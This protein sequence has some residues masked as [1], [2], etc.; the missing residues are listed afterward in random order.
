VYYL[1]TQYNGKHGGQWL[2]EE[3]IT[4]QLGIVFQSMQIPKDIAE[5][6]TVTL[7]EVHQNKIEFHNKHF[8]RLT[9]EHK[10][11]TKILD[12]LYLDKLKMR[13]TESDYDKF[14]ITLRDQLAD[15]NT[16]L[17]KLQEAEDNY[18]IT[19]KHILDLASRAYDLF[20][21]SEVEEK[22]QLIKLIL[23]NLR[24]SGKN[25][26]FDAQKPFDLL[27]DC[28]DSQVWHHLPDMFRKGEVTLTIR[29]TS[30]HTVYS[31]FKIKLK[32]H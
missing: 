16:Q 32:I 8:D 1:C 13:I 7:N 3:E 11:T 30:I 10:Q 23:S 19:A 29:L 14:Y 18:Y 28:G 5:Q 27:L 24:L 26:V 20:K 9:K 15:L 12:N 17:E 31:S 21:S 6:I 25:L 22:R 2:W 4:R